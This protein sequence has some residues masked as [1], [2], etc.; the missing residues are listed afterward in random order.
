MSLE[1]SS[2]KDR[3]EKVEK[4]KVLELK[5]ILKKAA[6]HEP[7]LSG[8]SNSSYKLRVSLSIILLYNI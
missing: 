1:L 2:N 6:S 5:T 7:S 4:R 8:M 3:W